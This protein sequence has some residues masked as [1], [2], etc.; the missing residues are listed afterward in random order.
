[1]KTLLSITS[2][3]YPPALKPGL[4]LIVLESKE[5]ENITELIAV[6]ALRGTFDLL[7]AGEWLPNQDRL[8]RA[9]HRH[10]AAVKEVLDHPIL[11][12]PFT[13]FQLRD[14]LEQANSQNRLMLILDFLHHFYDP[15]VDLALRQRV[16]E[17]CC[18]HLQH[19]SRT[20]PMIALV[21]HL[22]VDEYQQFFPLLASMADE[23]L[24]AQEDSATEAFQNSLF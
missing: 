21:Q 22:P 15:D 12:R 2:K 19:L 5:H 14:Q 16:L 3:H 8:R 24:E 10:T 4:L 9:V 6:L 20:R 18:K 7:A 11:M 1:M 23:I 13:C 17:Q